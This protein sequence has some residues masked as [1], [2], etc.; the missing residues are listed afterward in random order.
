VILGLSYSLSGFIL[1]ATVIL[2]IKM[3]SATSIEQYEEQ[4]SWLILALFGAT[5]A[6]DLLIAASMCY[7]TLK[8]RHLLEKSY[9]AFWDTFDV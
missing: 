4:W 1:G 6:V 5:A 7:Y 9:V 2:S 3:F 8:N